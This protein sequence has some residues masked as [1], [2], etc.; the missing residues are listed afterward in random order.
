MS[1]PGRAIGCVLGLGAGVLAWSLA[2]AALFH[3]IRSAEVPL[4]LGGPGRSLTVLHISDLHMLPR[5][6]ARQRFIHS[7]A[8]RTRPDLVIV[9]GDLL[10]SAGAVPAVLQ[11]LDPLLDLPGAFVFGSN[12]Y[13]APKPR[14]PLRY[15][16]DRSAPREPRK[17]QLPAAALAA[18]LQERGWLDLN[19]ARGQVRVQGIAVSMV[20]V[21]DPHIQRDRYP[22]DDG[23]RGELHLAVAHAPYQRILDAFLAEDAAVAFSGHTHGG[24]VCVPGFGA[25][26]TN[27]D[28]PTWRASGLQGWPGLRPDGDAVRPRP[29]FAHV[30]LSDAPSPMWLNISAGLG[31]SP[32]APVRLACP[33]EVSVLRLVHAPDF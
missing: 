19:N 21:D 5:Q 16:W 2:E 24:Q 28:M 12:D 15:L 8:A 32:F 20:G 17:V 6:R 10:A 22:A 7:L 26:V 29:P 1:K 3:R 14:N 11:A 13:H 33:P 18:A 27:C 25:L 4:N 23:T 9:T 30:P 31:T